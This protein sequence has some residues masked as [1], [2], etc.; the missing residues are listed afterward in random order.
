MTSLRA[1]END[2]QN[3]TLSARS[4]QFCTLYGG[5]SVAP[6]HFPL[7]SFEMTVHLFLLLRLHLRNQLRIHIV[8][9]DVLIISFTR[10]RQLFQVF[11]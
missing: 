8:T 4:P 1:I 6:S 10:Y 2:Q 3:G 11:C 5:F 9:G 7:L